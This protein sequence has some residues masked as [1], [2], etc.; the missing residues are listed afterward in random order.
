M[1]RHSVRLQANPDTTR[2][3]INMSQISF[4]GGAAG[5]LFAVGTVI[6]FLLGIPSLI[7]FPIGAL[8][9]GLVM[10]ILLRIR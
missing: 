10:S 7:W 8:S 3:G 6:I 1:I 4:D 9:L 2:P 5:L